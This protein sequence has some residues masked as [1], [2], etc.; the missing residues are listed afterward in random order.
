MKKRP[1]SPHLTLYSP[2][3]TSVSSI[4]GR[5]AGIYVYIITIFIGFFM[6]FNIQNRKD[7]GNILDSITLVM[8]A[9]IAFYVGF[10]IF[11]FISVFA[12]F[13]YIFALMRHLI[14]DFTYCLELKIATALGYGMFILSFI[15]ASVLITYMFFI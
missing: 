2:L 12:F 4:L 15:I 1:V 9:N 8:Q 3:I 11:A 6:A 5:M 7:V 14:W 13:L 10:V